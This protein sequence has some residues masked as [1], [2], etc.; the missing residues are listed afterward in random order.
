MSERI[1]YNKVKPTL[2]RVFFNDY[3]LASS[4]KIFLQTKLQSIVN[5]LQDDNTVD[6]DV[7][8]GALETMQTTVRTGLKTEEYDQVREV[9]PL[10]TDCRLFNYT[11]TAKYANTLITQAIDDIETILKA[12]ASSTLSA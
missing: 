12:T 4:Y 10:V 7:I 6:A 3:L 1:D 5:T 8:K 2:D 9:E 11:A